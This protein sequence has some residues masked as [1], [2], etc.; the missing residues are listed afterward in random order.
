M[1]SL[2]DIKKAKDIGRTIKQARESQHMSIQALAHLSGYTIH[3]MVNLENG[4]FFA[5]SENIDDL[6]ACARHCSKVIGLDWVNSPVLMQESMFKKIDEPESIPAF[7][8]KT[9]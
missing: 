4:N 2:V 9:A 8:Q 3:Q 7:L 6:L 5:F 1:T